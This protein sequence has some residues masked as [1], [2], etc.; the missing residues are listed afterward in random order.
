MM[1]LIFLST[2]AA[3]SLPA[4]AAPTTPAHA[5]LAARQEL[6]L[7]CLRSSSAYTIMAPSVAEE[8]CPDLCGTLWTYL[9][10][11]GSCSATNTNCGWDGS[12]FKWEFQVT[13]FCDEGKIDS[14]WWG[15]TENRYGALSC[16][17]DTPT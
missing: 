13:A 14:V 1:K 17:A 6:S 7:S 9:D 5:A 11:W 10:A 4:F 12:Q 16:I 15:A 3:G 2:L 8:D